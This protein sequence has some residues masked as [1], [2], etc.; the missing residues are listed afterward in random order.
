MGPGLSTQEPYLI[1]P[2][3]SPG[4]QAILLSHSIDKK[5]EAQGR[6]KLAGFPPVGKISVRF[7]LQSFGLQSWRCC[8]LGTP[9]QPLPQEHTNPGL[10]MEL[11]RGQECDNTYCPCEVTR[12]PVS[13]NRNIPDPPRSQMGFSWGGEAHFIEDA[14]AKRG[15]DMPKVTQWWMAGVGEHQ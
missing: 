12:H 3:V 1:Y 6:K 15:G 13:C 11:C 14:E 5:T 2:L 9:S 7:E 10:W 4:R 8:V